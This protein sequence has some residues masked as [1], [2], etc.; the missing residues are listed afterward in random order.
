METDNA[1]ISLVEAVREP[2]ESQFGVE[3]QISIEDDL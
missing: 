1:V 2:W 3:L